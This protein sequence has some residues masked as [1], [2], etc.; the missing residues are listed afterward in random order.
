MTPPYPLIG[1]QVIQRNNTLESK[2]YGGGTT[3]EI[4]SYIYRADGYPL[5]IIR[6]D[7]NGGL[8]EF[9]SKG[10]YIYTR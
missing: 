5:S 3:H 9:L 1:Q 2:H 7:I 10:Y 6:M 8:P 4:D